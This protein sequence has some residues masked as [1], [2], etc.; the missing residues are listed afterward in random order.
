MQAK[1]YGV[2]RCWRYIIK[3]SLNMLSPPFTRRRG[4]SNIQPNWT[5]SYIAC[6]SA[7]QV[8]K[9]HH[10]HYWNI[11]FFSVLKSIGIPNR[12][13]YRN[14]EWF[15][16]SSLDGS[17]LFTHVTYNL[18]DL[19]ETFMYKL[20]NAEIFTFTDRNLKTLDPRTISDNTYGR[21]FEIRLVNGHKQGRHDQ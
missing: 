7:A 4:Q 17:T 6:T 10:I 16:N 8:Y 9:I 2:W 3:G 13:D 14:G 1:F 11:I 21:C 5:S 20:E 15:G 12:N 19:I 18:S